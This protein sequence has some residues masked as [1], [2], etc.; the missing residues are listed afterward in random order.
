MAFVKIKANA[1]FQA[2]VPTPRGG[3]SAPMR[4]RLAHGFWT[5]GQVTQARA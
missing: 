2:P 4:E 1:Q 5:D 3:Q